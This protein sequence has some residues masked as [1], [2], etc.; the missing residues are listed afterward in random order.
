MQQILVVEDDHTM[1]EHLLQLLS[2]VPDICV[3][4]ASNEVEAQELVKQ[5]D[6]DLAI[7]DIELGQTALSRYAGLK[8]AQEKAA[9][10][11]LF[12]S[13]TSNA[14]V[15]S[16]ASY[17]FGYDFVSKP[18]DDLDFIVKVNRS[19]EVAQ[20]AKSQGPIAQLLLPPGLERNPQNQTKFMWQGKEVQL[21]V[22]ELGI[23]DRLARSFG[24]AVPH[25]ILENALPTGR[26]S[27][28]L[29]SHIR[30]IRQAFRDKDPEFVEI[31]TEPGRGYIW[32]PR[33][34]K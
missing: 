4:A 34:E 20:L 28:A 13:G 6:Y 2:Q 5:K 17:V 8:L 1:R 7:L 3:D 31:A 21:S 18:I 22:T 24:K 14:T 15:R 32:K 27:N 26:G 23:V 33:V 9:S 16:L 11:A 25:N 10:V 19:L 29:A 30:N 12:V